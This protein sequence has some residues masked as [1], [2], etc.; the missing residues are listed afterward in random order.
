[1]RKIRGT[2]IVSVACF[3]IAF[4]PQVAAIVF[5]GS[6]FGYGGYPDHS[7]NKPTKPIEPAFLDDHWEVDRYNWEVETY[8]NKLILYL[9]CIDE[10]VENANNDIKRIREAISSAIDEANS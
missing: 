9:N 2:H 1:M 4:C 10:Y 7:C 5:G 3:A 8:N 6:N